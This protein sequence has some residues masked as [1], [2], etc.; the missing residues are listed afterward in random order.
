MA[1]AL[2][3]VQD[4]IGQFGGDISRVT[5][6]GESAGAGGVMLLGI[7][8][9]GTLGTSLFN[10]VS[11]SNHSPEPLLTSFQIVAA[12]P[13]LPPQYN[14]N[15]SAPTQKYEEF[16]SRAGCGGG[17]ST[18]KLSCLRSVDSVTL[19]TANSAENSANFYGNW[20]FLPVTEPDTGFIT[21]VPSDSLT[22]KRVNGQ[23]VL[24]GN[25]ADEG[26]L[27]V[28]TNITNTAALQTWLQGVYPSLTSSELDTVL[29]AYPASNDTDTDRFATTGLGPETALDVSQFATGAQQRANNIYAEATF[30][31]PSYWLSSAFDGG[32][33]TAFHYQYSVPAALHGN[34]VSAYFGPA[35]PNQPPVFTSVFRQIWGGFIETTNP[36]T[37]LGLGNLTWPAWVDDGKSAMFNLNTTGGVPFQ[38]PQLIGVNV[39]EFMEPGVQNDFSVVD[40]LT[41]EGGRGERCEIWK[42]IASRIPI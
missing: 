28:P 11:N 34:D 22:A 15:A 39:T 40:A 14:F 12:S 8:Q 5:I 21:T 2:Q 20:A 6:S 1:F 18:E 9:N 29:A 41:W 19:Q 36:T 32:N 13:Y 38:S 26:P 30:V 42:S 23:H 4:H 16:A 3:W 24:V 25:N 37:T 35:A 10:Q 27:F 31:C 33:R 17:N 7:A